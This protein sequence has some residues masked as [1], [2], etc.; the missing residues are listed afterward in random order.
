MLV[1]YQGEEMG[2]LPRE[3][4]FILRTYKLGVQQVEETEPW[5]PGSRQLYVEPRQVDPYNLN[6][7]NWI[8]A[9]SKDSFGGLVIVTHTGNRNLRSNR[10]GHMAF[11]PGCGRL[12]SEL[13]ELGYNKWRNKALVPG[14]KHTGSHEQKR[15]GLNALKPCVHT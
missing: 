14:H 1:I 15:Q 10:M 5:R 4:S 2:L 6:L 7:G 8:Q 13:G 9:R 3:Q 11:V 12:Y